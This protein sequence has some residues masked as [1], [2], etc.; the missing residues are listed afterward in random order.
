MHASVM[1]KTENKLAIV[2]GLGKTGLSVVPYLFEQSYDVEVVDSRDLPPQLS[3]LQEVFPGI[4]VHTGDFDSE[5][6]QMADLIVVSPGVALSEP[7][8]SAARAAGVEV[9]GDIELFARAAKAPV[10]A[11]TG[12][13]GKSTV[14][15]LVAEMCSEAGLDTRLGGNIDIPALELLQDEEP[16]VYILELS[17]FQ[18]ETTTCLDA[19]AATVL[20]ITADHLDRY[21]GFDAYLRAKARIFNG[22]GAVIVNAEDPG[23][24]ATVP[25]G[26]KVTRFGMGPPLADDDYGLIKDAGKTWLVRGRERLFSSDE[27]TL[28]GRHNLANVLAALALTHVMGVHAAAARKVVKRFRGLPHRFQWVAE[29]NG[30]TWI[31][32]SKATNVGAAVAA[33]AGLTQ[34]VIWIAGGEGKDADFTPLQQVVR[35]NIRA[36]I[37]LGRDA[38]RIEVALK[39]LVPVYRV[40]DMGQAV[41]QAQALAKSG[42][43]VLLSPACA[44]F[45]M[46]SNFAQRGK[47]FENAVHQLI[48]KQSKETE[49]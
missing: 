40:S 35:K 15:A 16:D 2:I 13:N 46:F 19:R 6:L 8:I 10:I 25:A 31:N 49:S 12:S 20:N 45:D 38:D 44:S 11:I 21:P 33:L 28:P 41:S 29:N 30:I 34:P 39:E 37:L 24:L 17:S 9:I 4:T 5:R 18:L 27:I 42:D 23:V 36:A 43:A 22:R 32:D 48:S 26:R 3:T 7:A 47:A 14:S 1:T